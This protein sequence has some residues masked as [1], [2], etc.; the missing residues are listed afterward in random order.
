MD[1][2]IFAQSTCE[3]HQYTHFAS[4]KFKLPQKLLHILT[5]M[6]I[7]SF[8]ALLDLNFMEEFKL[9]CHAHFEFILHML[10]ISEILISS[11]KINII[12]IY[13]YNELVDTEQS[14][15]QM[16]ETCWQGVV[17]LFSKACLILFFLILM[18]FESS[19]KIR[20]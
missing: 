12:Y 5:Q 6:N 19:R 4:L 3:V 8:R 14:T 17:N 7:D 9:S 20:D 18:N 2:L 10:R 13:L 1:Y 16:I 11:T 15:S